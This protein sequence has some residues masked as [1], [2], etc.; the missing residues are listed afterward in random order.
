MILLK[1]H[2]D[3]EQCILLLTPAWHQ[4]PTS[5]FGSRS[6]KNRKRHFEK[7]LANP[8]TAFHV[9][10]QT[11]DGV[12]ACPVFKTR[13]DTVRPAS[14][15]QKQAPFGRV[16]QIGYSAAF[17]RSHSR[18]SCFV[19]RRAVCHRRRRAYIHCAY[20]HLY[21]PISTDRRADS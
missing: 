21:C 16:N 19:I 20:I 18:S 14:L 3:R 2:L 4:S 8:E 17:P 15:H 13:K 11:H 1:V 6:G 7:L 5:R 12:R 9:A 10:A